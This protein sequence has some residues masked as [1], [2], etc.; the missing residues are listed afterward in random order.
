MA[1][2]TASEW[3]RDYVTPAVPASG[4]NEP[5]KREGRAWG[6][7]LES[8][9]SANGGAG[10]AFATRAALL[11]DTTQSSGTTALV[12]ADPTAAYNGIWKWTPSSWARIGD[13]QNSVIPFTVTGGTANAIQVSAPETPTVP[14]AKLYLLTP[15]A[16]N[17]GAVTIAVNG[18]TPIAVKNAF[19]SALIA[20]SLI[21]GS[22]V[23]LAFS[24]DHYRLVISTNVDAS[25]ILSAAQ[26]A[27]TDAA[28]SAASVSTWANGGAG[29]LN[30]TAGTAN[31]Q[32][33]A[34]AGV[35]SLASEILIR[36]KVGSGLTNTAP[37]T[38]NVAATGAKPVMIYDY[39]GARQVAA[40]DIKEGRQY[41]AVYVSTIGVAGGWLIL[42]FTLL[43]PAIS[44][45]CLT[46]HTYLSTYTVARA[47]MN[48]A[49]L[50]GTFYA[51]P[52]TI[53]AGGWPSRAQLAIL[54]SEGWEIG[55]YPRNSGAGDLTLQGEYAASILATI[56][57]LIAKDAL[58]VAAGFPARTIVYPSR[59]AS[60]GLVNIVRQRYLAAAQFDDIAN[61]YDAYPLADPLRLRGGTYS[62]GDRGAGADGSE[63][64]KDTLA[65]LSAQLDA[66]IAAPVPSLWK[67]AIHEVGPTADASTIDET[68]F[69]D[70][71][72]Y[73]KT[74]KDAGLLR[75]CTIIEA[76]KPH[77]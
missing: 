56:N 74:K 16:A 31:A 64:G 65:S 17:T 60:A 61:P 52:E 12:Y 77:S 59:D 6:A 8:M 44:T 72:A 49:G 62:W 76:L 19:G 5:S 34:H 66:L 63:L 50:V 55:L 69:E 54:S 36:F 13:T 47:Y 11:A 53:D 10:L 30:T 26:T 39:L 68:T 38:L 57:K 15:T 25:A 2:P 33:L 14:G 43:T 51:I 37:L 58:M 67:A 20:D 32:T 22:M 29:P 41:L 45:L 1:I 70:F 9:L 46:F 21:V 27:A 7:W 40:G 4:A 28:A 3:L 71:L 18:E 24:V 23:I 48:V 42:N 75:V 73:V 35:S